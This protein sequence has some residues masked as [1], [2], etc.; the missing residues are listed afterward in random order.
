MLGTNAVDIKDLTKIF[1][2]RLIAVNGVTLSIPRG[3][4]F[5]LIGS[6]GAGKT[7]TLRLASVCTDQP[8]A[9]SPSSA[10]V[11]PFGQAACAAGWA[12][13]RRP[14]TSPRT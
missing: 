12:S 9:A 4:V 3:A 11:C 7:T 5:G 13:C 8:P 14:T 2:G 6:N 10:S 1:G